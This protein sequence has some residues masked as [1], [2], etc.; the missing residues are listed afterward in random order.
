MSRAWR[1]CARV[2]QA[3]VRARRARRQP[4]RPRPAGSL[5]SRAAPARPA[6][7][8]GLVRLQIRGDVSRACPSRIA[9]RRSNGRRTNRAFGSSWPMCAGRVEARVRVCG[10]GLNRIGRSSPT[11]FL[12]D[13]RCG[14]SSG[15]LSQ[16]LEASA[17]Y[18]ENVWSFSRKP[19][20]RSCIPWCA[21]LSAP[22][23]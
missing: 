2:D 13:D 23:W 6:A 19:K 20:P 8:G 5:R 17:R 14:E 3:R 16:S 1:P 4:A 21:A 7:R 15:R 10:R 12:G 18:L 22:S 9:W 11:C